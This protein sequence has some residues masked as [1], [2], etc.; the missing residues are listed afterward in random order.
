MNIFE[1]LLKK[2]PEIKD[3]IDLFEETISDQTYLSESQIRIIA[4]ASCAQ[5]KHV[6]IKK[7][8]ENKIGKLTTE[9]EKIVL[10]ASSRMS[11]TNPYFMGR[12]VHSVKAGGTLDVLNLRQFMALK[13][14]DVVAYHYAC[15][16]FSLL[17]AGYMCFDS[18]ITSL[19]RLQ[20]NPEAIDQAMKL[21]VSIASI[22]QLISNESILNLE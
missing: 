10:I 4:W 17:N 15:I 16:S 12:N 21:T 11:I 22:R 20:Q 3:Q 5:L 19:E 2:Y 13:I 1:N 7:I 6:E 9:E 14:Y 8:I 18:H